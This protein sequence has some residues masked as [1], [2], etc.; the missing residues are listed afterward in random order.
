MIPELL[1]VTETAFKLKMSASNLRRLMREGQIEYMKRP[2]FAGRVLFTE[3]QITDYLNS[4][5]TV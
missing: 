1:T 3:K 5:C 2:G 4:K